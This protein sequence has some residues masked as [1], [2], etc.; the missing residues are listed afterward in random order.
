MSQ[1]HF[2]LNYTRQDLAEYL[3]WFGKLESLERLDVDPSRRNLYTVVAVIGETV[4][5]L[6]GI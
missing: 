4:P 5:K 3:V 1:S 2:T 6:V